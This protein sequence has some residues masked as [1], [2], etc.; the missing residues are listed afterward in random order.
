MSFSEEVARGWTLAM[1]AADLDGDLLPEIYF[2]NDFG[3]D[4][5][6]H[7][8]STPGQ[9]TICSSSKA[10]AISRLR[11]PACWATIPSRAWAWTS[12]TSMATACSTFTSATSRTKF[13]LTESH[14]LWLSTRRAR[15][16][17]ATASPL[18]QAAKN[19]GSPAAAL[20]WDARLADFD[21]DGVLEAM[22]ACGFIKGK[23][24]RW[25]E[26]QALGTSNNQIVHN[27]RFWPS[28]R[29]GADL[30]GHDCNPF[31]VRG[32]DGR[33]HDIAA[34]S[35]AWP[36]P[37][38]ARHR[39]RR[40]GWRWPAGFRHRQPMGHVLLFPQRIADA[41]RVSRSGSAPAGRS[42]RNGSSAH[43]IRSDIGGPPSA[44][45]PRCGSPTDAGLVSQV[46]G[47]TGHS[48]E[49][50]V[51]TSISVSAGSMATKPVRVEMQMARR[52]RP[53]A[54]G[55]TQLHSWLAPRACSATPTVLTRSPQLR[56]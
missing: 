37:W 50:A 55:C 39:H 13:G 10:A 49:C 34:G 20:A 24:N 19:S 52:R 4:R 41:R 18:F 42:A 27:P 12:A 29:P 3:P 48:G 8:R 51:P 47:G 38:S 17:E 5:L 53:A 32:A 9:L 35:S 36:K 16:N 31:F 7:N 15:R 1:G 2:A 46:D 22:Q 21:N 30:S 44:P 26:L 45:W 23:I 54:A 6:L 56:R 11:N 40:C 28:F 33:Y 14:F 43:S 25:P